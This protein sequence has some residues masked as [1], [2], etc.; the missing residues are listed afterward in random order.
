MNTL[1]EFETSAFELE[2]P[3]ARD[4]TQP[5][6]RELE[7]EAEDET[8]LQLLRAQPTRTSASIA[9]AII[10][11]AKQ[12]RFRADDGSASGLLVVNRVTFAVESPSSG[13]Q[14]SGRRKYDPVTVTHPV[15]PASPQLFTALTTNEVLT[16]VHLELRRTADPSDTTPAYI[17]DLKDARVVRI[18]LINQSDNTASPIQMPLQ[19]ELAIV[20]ARVE[21]T[22][23]TGN[24]TSTDSWQNV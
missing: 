23:T 16:K 4:A 12:G 20:F 22:S 3:F 10:D 19:E 7:H 14:A 6:P 15:G 17:I 24:T 13:N 5:Q 11:G 8:R 9:T 1:T 21:V 18:R 2:S